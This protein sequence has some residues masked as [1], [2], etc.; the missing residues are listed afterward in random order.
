MECF[1]SQRTMRWWGGPA[2]VPQGNTVVL[3]WYPSVKISDGAGGGLA[4]IHYWELNSSTIDD[5]IPCPVT[6]LSNP[7]DKE[8]DDYIEWMEANDGDWSFMDYDPTNEWAETYLAGRAAIVA[9]PSYGSGGG[10]A[11][12]FG[13]HPEDPIWQDD[14]IQDEE[15]N[16]S[17]TLMN[18][19]YTWQGP[20]TAYYSSTEYN[21]RM[22]RRA[23][24]W[25]AGDVPDSST[26][27]P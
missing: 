2:F 11:V 8:L 6:S 1:E 3:G 18:G 13:P 9:N 24:A 27:L 14:V 15:D 25:V 5:T 12:A 20:H 22:L 19:L 4:P 17:N 26:E 23:A 16:S 10:R 7:T 21:W